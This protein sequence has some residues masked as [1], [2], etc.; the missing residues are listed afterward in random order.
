MATDPIYTR[1]SLS[2][3][4]FFFFFSIF[5]T[6]ILYV[7]IWAR[8]LISVVEAVSISFLFSGLMRKRKAVVI[9]S[10][11]EYYVVLFGTLY[12]SRRSCCAVL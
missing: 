10:E 9:V 12:Y 11:S 5:C 2:P 8:Q 6:R 1:S 4:P 7:G 3:S